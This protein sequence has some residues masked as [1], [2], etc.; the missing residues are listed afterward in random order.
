MKKLFEDSRELDFSELLK[1]N[2]GYASDSTIPSNHERISIING[3][4][5]SSLTGFIAPSKPKNIPDYLSVNNTLNQQDFD[6]EYGFSDGELAHTKSCKTAALINAYVVEYGLNKETLDKAVET[7]KDK[8][9]IDS[10]GSPLDI[11]K[12]SNS[13]SKLM[14]LDTHFETAGKMEG[15]KWVVCK[16]NV[17]G[18]DSYT[19]LGTG[20]L[21]STNANLGTSHYTLV[22]PNGSRI[23]S[24]DPNR[25]AAPGY[26]GMTF[27]PFVT[28]R[29]Y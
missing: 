26:K 14:G 25:D 22:Q 15:N 2:G 27:E 21:L 4:A 11:N 18:I 10:D 7:W 8:K 28:I 1:I 16:I 9:Y 12:M 3:Q 20:I 24:L 5:Y 19:N 29:N 6:R 13:L 23:D 17:S